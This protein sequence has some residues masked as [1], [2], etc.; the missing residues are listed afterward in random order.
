MLVGEQPGD[1]EDIEG[2]PFAGPAG[3]LLDR[4]L[5]EA[6]IDREQT[7][8]TNVVKH[9]DW[10]P[11]PRGERRMHSK[12]NAA[13]IKACKPWLGQEIRLVQP[14]VL[15]V[16]GATAAQALLGARFR[17]LKERGRPISGTEWAPIVVATVHPASILR[18]P[19]DAERRRQY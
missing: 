17:V 14:R 7:F 12:P 9:F 16:L 4:A 18:A 5:A 2:H 11:A 10:T 13:Q 6:G 1:R 8:V 3:N 19:D 15:I